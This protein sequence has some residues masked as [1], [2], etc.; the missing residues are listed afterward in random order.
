[1]W[2]TQEDLVSA[3]GS[4]GLLL[5][6]HDTVLLIVCGGIHSE[7]VEKLF[8]T[9]TVFVHVLHNGHAQIAVT[10]LFFLQFFAAK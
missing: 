10:M 6:V 5:A 7:K 2:A 4:S 3:A 9:E 1:M 8:G